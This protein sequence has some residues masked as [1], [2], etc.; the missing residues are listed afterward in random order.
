MV[1][2]AVRRAVVEE[3]HQLDARIGGG[4]QAVGQRTALLV[5]A[6]HHR[7]QRRS[8]QPHQVRRGTAQPP[9]HQQLRRGREPQPVQHHGARK[10]L[11]VPG[12]KRH[13]QQQAGRPAPG[14]QR[15]DEHLVQRQ[16]Q[17]GAAGKSQ[18]ESHDGRDEP[19]WR[20]LVFEEPDQQPQRQHGDYRFED[21]LHCVQQ[22]A[23]AQLGS[24]SRRRRRGRNPRQRFRLMHRSRSASASRRPGRGWSRPACRRCFSCGS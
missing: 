21:R 23:F 13:H 22:P 17:L 16:S 12:G 2:V 10:I 7:S 15:A 11:D 5:H 18:R 8:L 14:Q 9:M 6:H 1:M 3:A 20:E 4:A 24:G 19:G